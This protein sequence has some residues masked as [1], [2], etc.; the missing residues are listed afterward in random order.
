MS[1]STSCHKLNYWPHI[2]RRR[3]T[4]YPNRTVLRNNETLYLNWLTHGRSLV[5]YISSDP[6]LVRRVDRN[7]ISGRREKVS[8]LCFLW[9][10]NMFCRYWR[11]KPEVSCGLQ[12]LYKTQGTD[13]TGCSIWKAPYP[14]VA[15]DALLAIGTAVI[16]TVL[17]LGKHLSQ[18]NIS[19]VQKCCYQSVYCCLI[20][21]CQETHC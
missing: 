20:L 6:L 16:P 14:I 17:S 11:K 7:P 5:D 3:K 19:Y 4:S 18:T 8:L 10:D 1:E 9:T 15:A 12:T 2:P 13:H 21:F